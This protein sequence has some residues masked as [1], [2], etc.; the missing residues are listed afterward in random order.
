[1]R[2]VQDVIEEYDP[3]DRT[4][5]KKILLIEWFQEYPGKRFDITE[6]HQELGDELDIGRT[7]TGQIL[8][9]LEEESVLDSHGNQRK[10]YE[11]SEDILIP[12]KYQAIAGLRHLWTVVDINRWGVIGFLVMA[13]IL[14]FFLTFPFWFFSVALLVL[15]SDQVG[16]LS[17]SEIIV[18]TLSMTIWLLTLTICTSVLQM[19]RRWWTDKTTYQ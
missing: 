2:D 4:D 9:E 3:S 10:A 18:M 14:W 6:V 8:K 13:T 7:R 1:M 19:A 16:P 11:L 15:P 12:V 5:N 17:E